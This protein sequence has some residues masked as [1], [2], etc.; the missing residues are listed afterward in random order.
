MLLIYFEKYSFTF[1]VSH[2]LSIMCSLL[3]TILKDSFVIIRL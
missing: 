2:L 3:R 1:D